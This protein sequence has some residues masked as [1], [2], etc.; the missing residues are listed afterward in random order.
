[1]TDRPLPP[2]GSPEGSPHPQAAR[3]FARLLRLRRE[4]EPPARE[5]LQPLV[6]Y[7]TGLRRGADVP[8]RA[9]VDPRGIAPL[10]P[11]TFLLERIAPGLAR[12]RLAGSDLAGLMGMDVRGMPL[13]AMLTPAA[14][15]ALLGPLEQVFDEPAMLE[16]VLGAPGGPGKPE[17]AA[18]LVVLPL[19]GECGQVVRAIGAL[20]TSGGRPGRAPRRF[21]IRS[22][23]LTNVLS[24]PLPASPSASPL[25]NP[26]PLAFTDFRE[27]PARPARPPYLRLV[28]SV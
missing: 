24:L 11:H 12:F 28:H 16:M 25:Q 19:R 26:E 27:A 9:E 17:L 20:V 22:V 13:S 18:R 6:E 21:H 7:W 2:E 3:P 5:T 14:R 1:M 10:L 4:A 15:D 8:R 23:A